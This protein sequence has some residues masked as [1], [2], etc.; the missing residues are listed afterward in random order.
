MNLTRQTKLYKSTFD[1]KEVIYR[2]LNIT[3]INV[4]NNISN[5]YYKYD[6]AYDLAVINKDDEINYLIKQQIGK[7]IIESSALSLSDD[8]ILSLTV[9]G[10]R[11]SVKND[12]TLTLIPQIMNVLNVNLEYLLS[13]TIDDLIELT[14]LCEIMTNKKIF[15]DIDMPKEDVAIKNDNPQFFPED[16]KSLQD[17]MKE[18]E[19]F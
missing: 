4:I 19:G 13:L 6:V 2:T 7:D 10:F 1:D 12:F 16:G 5:T 14:A 11:E 3:E 15:K 18:L 17:K 8:M 9:D